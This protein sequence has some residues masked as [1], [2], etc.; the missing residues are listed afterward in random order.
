[1]NNEITA[2]EFSIHYGDV[3]TNKFIVVQENSF[4][5]ITSPHIARSRYN[6]LFQMVPAIGKPLVFLRNTYNMFNNLPCYFQYV[7]NRG[8]LDS[9]IAYGQILNFSIVIDKNLPEH[10]LMT[11]CRWI[12]GSAFNTT[13]PIVVSKRMIKNFPLPPKVLCV[14]SKDSK[15]DCYTDTIATVY[16]GQLLTVMFSLN[17][18]MLHSEEEPSYQIIFLV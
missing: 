17:H 2:I 5:K 1:M 4:I 14:C 3:N 7:S 11:H 16:P 12:P 15:P 8:N 18:T 10:C 13:R 6:V 9:E